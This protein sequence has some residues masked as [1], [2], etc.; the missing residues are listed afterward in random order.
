MRL[1]SLWKTKDLGRRK[2]TETRSAEFQEFPFGQ[3]RLADGSVSKAVSDKGLAH[4]RSIIVNRK[5]DG[6]QKS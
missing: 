5:L 3:V 2:E 4:K 1:G 6:S